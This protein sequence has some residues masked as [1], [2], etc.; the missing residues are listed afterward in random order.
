[1]SEDNC[2]QIFSILIF[3]YNNLF[4]Y[5][6]G[7]YETGL[8]NLQTQKQKF[9]LVV[10]AYFYYLLYIRHSPT[11]VYVKIMSKVVFFIKSLSLLA[12]WS[13]SSFE[14][15]SFNSVA[16]SIHTEHIPEWSWNSFKPIS[17]YIWLFRCDYSVYLLTHQTTIKLF[18]A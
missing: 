11:M 6:E 4:R 10:Y 12:F 18:T 3:N 14:Y 16:N 15:C 17:L 13:I 9:C 5:Y 7:Y 2:A 1:M 8:L